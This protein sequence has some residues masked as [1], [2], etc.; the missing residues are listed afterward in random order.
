MVDWFIRYCGGLISV[1]S[2]PTD[3]TG[4]FPAHLNYGLLSFSLAILISPWHREIGDSQ[5]STPDQSTGRCYYP[6]LQVT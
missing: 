3:P 4:M 2:V 5:Y 1:L 6:F